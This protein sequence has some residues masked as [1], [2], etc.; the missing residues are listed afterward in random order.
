M[1]QIQDRVM[2]LQEGLLCAY[3]R[4]AGLQDTQGKMPGARGQGQGRR[5]PGIGTGTGVR[6]TGDVCFKRPEKCIMMALDPI[7]DST[8]CLNTPSSDS[9]AHCCNQ[10]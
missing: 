10:L 3:V 6:H 4:R 1:P 5:Y 9:S 2:G 8:R 7:G